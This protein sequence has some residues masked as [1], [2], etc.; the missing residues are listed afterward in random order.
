MT[1]GMSRL[2]TRQT[3]SQQR[4]RTTAEVL[5]P[6]NRIGK[7]VTFRRI[8]IVILVLLLTIDTGFLILTPRE[9]NG[10]FLLIAGL[11]LVV[12]LGLACSF[13]G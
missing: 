2:A 6:L 7:A 5:L 13:Q 3:V 9:P 4:N 12:L 8:V 10:V 1:V 11:W